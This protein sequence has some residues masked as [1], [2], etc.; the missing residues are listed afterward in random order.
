MPDVYGFGNK[1]AGVHHRLAKM[2][3]RDAALGQVLALHR[4]C[5]QV[6]ALDGRLCQMPA[7]HRTGL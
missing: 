3:G 4:T 7:L 6:L 1:M 5:S 2:P